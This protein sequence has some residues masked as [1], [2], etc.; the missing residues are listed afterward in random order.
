MSSGGVYSALNPPLKLIQVSNLT[1]FEA[2]KAKSIEYS[3]DDDNQYKCMYDYT[4]AGVVLYYISQ[5]GQ[6]QIISGT[7]S[8]YVFD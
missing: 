3:A 6:P 7:S 2:R 8:V 4:R 1:I 5:S